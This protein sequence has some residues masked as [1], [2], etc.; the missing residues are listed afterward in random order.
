MAALEFRCREEAAEPRPVVVDSDIAIAVVAALVSGRQTEFGVMV[1]LDGPREA[2]MPASLCFGY[3]VSAEDGSI[4]RPPA[5]GA[6][7]KRP[8]RILASAR[9]DLRPWGNETRQ[10]TIERVLNELGEAT[11]AGWRL[12]TA[13]RMAPALDRSVRALHAGPDELPPPPGPGGALLDGRGVLVGVVDFGCD[14]AHPAFRTVAGDTRLHLLWDQNGTGPGG[15]ARMGLPGRFFDAAMIDAA[16]S[17]PDPYAALGYRPA[18]NA[19]APST[20]VPGAPVH[21]THVLGVAGGRGVRGCPAGVAPGAALAFVH[22]RAD[23][24]VADG[25]ATDVFDGVCCIF[26]SAGAWPAVV[27]LSIGDNG[28]PHDGSTLFDHA[29]D[30]LLLRP[31]RAITVAAGNAREAHRHATGAVSRD[32]PSVLEWRFGAEDETPNVLRI[33]CEGD[34]AHPPLRCVLTDPDDRR[35]ALDPGATA[36]VRITLDRGKQKLAGMAYAG[37]SPCM[38]GPP[39]QHIELRVPPRGDG[40]EEVW[41]VALQLT[42]DV[43][44]AARFDAWVE[45]D[46][47]TQKAQSSFVPQ[48]GDA[49]RGCSLGS[50]ACGRRTICVGAYDATVPGAEP[51]A[52]SSA[53]PT[54]DGREKPDIVAPGIEVRA[55]FAGGGRPMEGS[56]F[57]NPMR[58]VMHGTSVAAPH[59]AGVA[60]LMLQANPTLDAEAIR[61]G[62]RAT[63]QR[64][65]PAD[66]ERP[67]HPRLGCGPLDGAAAIAWAIAR[68]QP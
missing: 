50:V 59:A 13:P 39:L 37:L 2:A 9:L 17:R 3:G 62:M 24:I 48:P 22:L 25:D 63:T 36:G 61:E 4:L 5:A 20:A 55:A 66:A 8:G 45:R 52:F 47:R 31:G 56:A 26:D 67:W 33:F 51:A 64:P 60:A 40:V 27:N 14:F 42:R 34:A 23:A 1:Q 58:G 41:T 12:Q 6:H 44:D 7:F 54:R 65:P 53:G 32:A 43:A 28:G 15:E 18:A 57:I 16:L 49:D 11:A 30:A 68:R 35:T 19:Y 46:D 38:R 29:L 10:Q 21:G